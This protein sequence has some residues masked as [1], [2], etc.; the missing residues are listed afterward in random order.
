MY[1][2]TQYI[3]STSYVEDCQTH[4]AFFHVCNLL[5]INAEGYVS[6]ACNRV[7]N[8]L[9]NRLCRWFERLNMYYFQMSNMFCN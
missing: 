2:T 6:L 8:A 5:Y 3:A 9:W 4:I 1:Y 7:C